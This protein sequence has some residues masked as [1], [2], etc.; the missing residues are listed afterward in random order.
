MSVMV[1]VEVDFD[2]K[3]LGNNL[4]NFDDRLRRNVSAVVDYEAA[5]ATTWLKHNARWTD[6]TGAA[7]SGLMALPN[8]GKTYEEIIMRYSVYYGI[9]LEV[10]HDRKY[11]VITPAIR[12]IGA[13]LMQDLQH[14]I[15]RMPKT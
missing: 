3:R 15:D 5:Y 7:R 14:L 11:A 1:S 9:W 6:R 4:R 12:I 10:A 2:G 8:H 13:K